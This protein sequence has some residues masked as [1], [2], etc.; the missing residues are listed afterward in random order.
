MKHRLHSKISHAK[1]GITDITKC[2]FHACC[3]LKSRCVMV[4]SSGQ[5]LRDLVSADPDRTK[6]Q[7]TLKLE[8][9]K[10]EGRHLVEIL[11][12]GPESI[13]LGSVSQSGIYFPIIAS[14][15]LG[16]IRNEQ[17]SHISGNFVSDFG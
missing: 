9:D 2:Q 16:L 8:P 17:R 6:A 7:G 1:S 13:K 4:H 14:F 5:F 10:A 11:S 3:A 12:Q 15:F